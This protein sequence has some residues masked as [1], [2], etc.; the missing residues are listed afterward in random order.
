[1]TFYGAM[2]GAKPPTVRIGASY[3]S[4]ARVVQR[5]HHEHGTH[6]CDFCSDGALFGDDVL[7]L[8]HIVTFGE[9]QPARLVLLM[10]DRILGCGTG[11]DRVHRCSARDSLARSVEDEEGERN[12]KRG[13]CTEDRGATQYSA[14]ETKTDHDHSPQ[15]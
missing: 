6:R 1:M 3:S 10:I 9:T 11:N 14:K 12:E 5:R 8:V 13:R 2:P 7:A 15:V 4:L